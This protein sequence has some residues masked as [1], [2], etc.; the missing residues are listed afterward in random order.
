MLNYPSKTLKIL[1]MGPFLLI[2]VF[3]LCFGDFG[4]FGVS[5]LF[6]CVL[7]SF[8]CS[9][10]GVLL[11]AGRLSL[12]CLLYIDLY[13]DGSFRSTIAQHVSSLFGFFGGH[14]TTCIIAGGHPVINQYP[15]SLKQKHR[16][17]FTSFPETQTVK[18]MLTSDNWLTKQ[19]WNAYSNY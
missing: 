12:G 8:V 16:L 11:S 3:D 6:A 13:F 17:Y 9:C 10:I 5:L 14:S 19:V 2:I 15:V 1:L 18:C 7:C 4:G